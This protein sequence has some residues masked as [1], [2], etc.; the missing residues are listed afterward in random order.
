MGRDW[1][2]EGLE[3]RI[4][5]IKSGEEKRRKKRSARVGRGRA[6]GPRL[7]EEEGGVLGEEELPRAAVGY[8]GTPSISAA[9]QRPH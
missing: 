6:I 3:K 2:T 9:L 5:A 7:A 1:K 4:S 8:N